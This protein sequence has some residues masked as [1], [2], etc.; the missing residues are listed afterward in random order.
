M[1]WWYS[2]SQRE[3]PGLAGSSPRAP[4]AERGLD[5]TTVAAPRDGVAAGIPRG[6]DA[7]GVAVLRGVAARGVEGAPERGGSALRLAVEPLA[8]GEAD[9][10]W[11]ST[12]EHARRKA[13]PRGLLRRFE[14]SRPTSLE[15]RCSK[16][17]RQSSSSDA[18]DL[19]APARPD[20]TAFAPA[21]VLSRSKASRPW[22]RDRKPSR[23]SRLMEPASSLSSSTARFSQK[24]SSSSAQ[25]M[26][27]RFSRM[28]GSWSRGTRCTSSPAGVDSGRQ[29]SK[30]SL[31]SL[32]RR[33]CQSA[34]EVL[35]RRVRHC[36]CA[37]AQASSSRRSCRFLRSSAS[38]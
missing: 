5:R 31:N 23:R 19:R 36:C 22:A 35:L 2:N 20:A 8:A 26:R 30:A 17:R 38:R 37:C 10:A 29:S 6:V 21:P 33:A 34:L 14:S 18:C 1:A 28:H 4:H 32:S 16:F 24:N 11:P 12:A 13:S 27:P 25:P 3:S 9:R 15:S 7:R